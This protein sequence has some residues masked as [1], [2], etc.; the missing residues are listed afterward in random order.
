MGVAAAG[1]AAEVIAE[2]RVHGNHTTP[3]A[4]VLGLAGLKTGGDAS[5]A[6]LGAAERALRD[7]GRFADVTIRRRFRSIDDPADILIVIVVDEHAAVS[8]DDLTPGVG[9]R[10]LSSGMWL[11]IFSYADGYGFTYG[12]Q[13]SFV[14]VA[15][16]RS[17]LSVPMTWGGERRI[18]LQLE[19]SF[20]R[21]VSV[22]RGGGSLTRKVNPHYE[23]P[24]RREEI[25]F[26]VERQWT[27]WLRT[28]ATA[29]LANVAFGP[30]YEARH[31]G[32]RAHLRVDT[33]VDPSF[34]RNAVHITTGWEWLTFAHGPG[35]PPASAGGVGRWDAD[36]RGYVGL[37]G[38]TV[39]ALRAQTSRADAP[40]P[41][42]E[43]AL[44]GGSDSLRGYAAGHRAG[45]RMLALSAELR[46]PLNSPVTAG[47]FGLKA[48]IDTGTTWRATDRLRDQTFDR[49]IG[50]GVYF[51]IGP[52]MSDVAVAWPRDGGPRGHFSLGVTF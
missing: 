30:A 25:R 51:G 9:K 41:L 26:D 50:S 44:L 13:F 38:S 23:L 16:E 35:D 37:F 8:A 42:V 52:L 36:A 32:T 43:Q 22:V 19:R 14:G 29:K 27:G 33:R 5:D 46:V 3:D 18:G 7:R 6:A 31:T 2:V 28:G 4:D 20:N 1:Q 21:V 47:R 12:A 10:I 17:Q 45:D 11:P 40:L 39:A 24:D 34:P 15:G 48:F 49:G